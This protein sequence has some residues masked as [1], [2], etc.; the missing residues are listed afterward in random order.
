MEQCELAAAR[1]AHRSRRW[2]SALPAWCTAGRA[3]RG[4]ALADRLGSGAAARL[5]SGG[6][7]ALGSAGVASRHGTQPRL[8][9]C[10][11][12]RDGQPAAGKRGRTSEAVAS[13]EALAERRLV[14]AVF[15]KAQAGEQGLSRWQCDPLRC[16]FAPSTRGTHATA[17]AIAAT[18]AAEL[19]AAR[20]CLN[21][22]AM[23]CTTASSCWSGS[24]AG[25]KL[26]AQKAADMVLR[27]PRGGGRGR[28]REG[29]NMAGV[30][31]Q[32]TGRL[33]SVH[34][35]VAKL[36]AACARTW[37][38]RWQRPSFGAQA[39][40]VLQPDPN[41][42]RLGPYLSTMLFTISA[43]LGCMPAWVVSA[44]S[45][46]SASVSCALLA[47]ASACSIASCPPAWPW[48]A[49]RPGLR[50]DRMEPGTARR[51]HR[52]ATG[53]AA[54]PLRCGGL[55]AQRL[56]GAGTHLRSC[57]SGTAPQPMPGAPGSGPRRL[58]AT[59]WPAPR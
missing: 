22:L 9:R 48:S 39:H 58:R 52:A 40:G 32:S 1:G 30:D 47:C 51:T 31:R 13:P 25:E 16:V 41:P 12:Y 43:A 38:V 19:A 2:R 27:V 49:G 34:A 57:W 20:A 55:A 44:H 46:P 26:K 33:I 29:L 15:G 17:H 36:C 37:L 42:P 18:G 8:G 28:G 35:P 50:H 3:A 21:R 56:A 14:P 5:H 53:V 54:L 6:V 24:A 4:T 59:S 7:G 10:T 11:R 23:T 45:V